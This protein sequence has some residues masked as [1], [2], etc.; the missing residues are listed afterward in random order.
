MLD[1]NFKTTAEDIGWLLIASSF[2]PIEHA[3]NSPQLDGV[4]VEKLEPI[5]GRSDLPA[6][7]NLKNLGTTK[8]I[9]QVCEDDYL[10]AM[11]VHNFML[12]TGA[13]SHL[14]Y[15]DYT[16]R[17]K[18]VWYVIADKIPD[19]LNRPVNHSVM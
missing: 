17:P 1:T 3:H 11:L 5:R 16:H 13:E 12:T 10:H 7:L 4:N 8:Y 14:L 15:D 19:I 6:Y 18:R 2:C 9:A